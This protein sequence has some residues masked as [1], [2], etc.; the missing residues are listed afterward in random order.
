MTAHALNQAGL[1][2]DTLAANYD[3]HFTTSHIGRA[4]RNVVWQKTREV[5][6]TPSHILELNCG[7]GEDALFLASQGHSV[8][9]LDAS[10]AMID[11]ASHRKQLEAPT[12]DIHF[13]PLPSEYLSAL[14]VKPFDAVFSNFSGLNCVPDLHRVSQQ[15]A[16]RTPPGAPVLLCLSTRICLWESVWFLLQ[17]KLHKAIRR[18]SGESTAALNGVHVTVYYPTVATVTKA[19]KPG[20]HLRSTTGVGIVVPPSYLEPWMRHCPRLLAWMTRIDRLLCRLP[21]F[22]TL[23]DHVL[24]HLER[25]QEAA[26]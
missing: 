16:L 23:G 4:Q 15:L 3:T 10:H 26:A 19:F 9:A 8:T 11:R 22:R 5:F 14:P 24:L 12:A 13:Q 2:F 18:W 17:G 6:R 1:A 21:L 7:T 25:T 20:F